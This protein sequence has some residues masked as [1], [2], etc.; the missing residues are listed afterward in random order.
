MDNAELFAGIDALKDEMI[1]IRHN[2]HQHPEIGYEEHLTSDLVA[3]R[4]T[5]WGYTVHRGLA[6]TGVIGQ[7]KNGEGPTIA[8][9][10]DMDALPLQEHNDL[11]YQSKHTG[12]MHACGHDGHTASMLAAARYL[13]EHR[14]FQGTVNLV[15]Q[16]AEEGLGGAPRMMQE[17]LFEAF[18]CDAIFGFHNIPNYPAGHFGFCHGPAMSSADAVTITITGKGGH[19]ALPHLS[20]DP[21]VVASSIVMALQ[22]IVARNLNPLDT[23]V[24]SVG[25]IHAGTATNIIPNNAVI[26]LTVRTLNQAVQTQVAERI[27]TI[28]T[29]QAQSYGATATVDYQKDVPVLINTE[30]ETRL[31]EDVARDL[32][33][34][35][36]VID[37]CPPVLASEDF[38]F[39]LEARPGCYLFVGNGTT[40][41]H[42][43]SLHNPHYDFNDDILPIVA[44]YWVKLVSTFCPQSKSIGE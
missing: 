14:P 37:H 13:A 17:G 7:L 29:L 11:P 5:Q 3:E 22:T 15:F 2:L 16:P 41:A 12:K 27:K 26:K 28:T 23:A 4:L 19:G 30:A 1:A 20:I 43:C 18:P 33:G 38:A 36:T 9:R 25:S 44:A 31:A 21:I 39:M 10:A 35:H 40:G 34:D 24:I 6:K 8:L 42:S 32:F